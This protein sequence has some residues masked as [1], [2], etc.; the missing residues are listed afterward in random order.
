MD[1]WG[2]V[3]GPFGLG[4]GNNAGKKI[5]NFCYSIEQPYATPCLKKAHTHANM[6]A[7]KIQTMALHRHCSDEEEGQEEVLRCSKQ[8]RSTMPHKPSAVAFQGGD[9]QQVV[10]HREKEAKNCEV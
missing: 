9:D 1:L 10:P 3:M 7:P 8:E 4:E 6:A 2:D 5:L